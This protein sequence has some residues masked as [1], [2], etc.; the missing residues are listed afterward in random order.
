V[1]AATNRPDLIDPALLRPGRIDRDI[2][3]EI[4]DLEARKKILKVHTQ[5]MPLSDDIDIDELA[6]ELEGYV[7]SDIESLC[8]EAAMLA[9]R[10]DT[11]AEEVR[12][13]HFKEAMEETQPTATD[14]N[15]EHYKQMMQKMDKVEKSED[16][17]DYYG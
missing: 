17:P 12:M 1:I 10:K 14:E 2:E 4:P 11:E 9:L 15:V 13:E 3:V 7:G 8:R 16:Q 5:K 6:E